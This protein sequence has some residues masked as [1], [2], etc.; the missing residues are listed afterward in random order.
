MKTSVQTKHRLLSYDRL[1]LENFTI[2]FVEKFNDFIRKEKTSKWKKE[3]LLTKKLFQ[4][5]QLII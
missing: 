3:F 2:F 5:T 4:N 1:L